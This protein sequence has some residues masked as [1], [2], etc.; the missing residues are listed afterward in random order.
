MTTSPT[1]TSAHTLRHGRRAVTVSIGVDGPTLSL[2]LDGRQLIPVKLGITVDGQPFGLGS[3]ITAVSQRTVTERVEMRTGKAAR[4]RDVVHEELD[5]E[6]TNELGRTWGV[7]LRVAPDGF[8][9]RYR[10]PG[11]TESVQLGAELTSFPTAPDQRAWVL[12]Y[13][14]WYETPRF[15]SDLAELSSGDY[16]FP[17]LLRVAA[18]DFLLFSESDIDGRFSGTHP[19]YTGSAFALATADPIVTLAGGTLTPW[20]VV[21]AGTLADVVE[22]SLVDELAP[23]AAQELQAASWIR[24]GRAAWSWWSS[25]YSG[26]YLNHQKRFADYAAARGWEHVLVD[27]GWDETWM[28][29]LVA[30]ASLRGVQV[31]VWSSWSDLDGPDALAKLALWRS[32]GVAGI[33]VDFMESEAL[34]RY[35]WYDAIIAESARVGL[36]VNF[37]GSVIPRGWARTHP[38]VMSYEGIRGAEYYVFYGDPLTA[39]HNV[40]QPFTRNVVGSMD[41]T[42]VTFSAPKRE[43]SDAHELALAVA[44]ES[45]IVHFADD[46]TE[47]AARPLAEA[48]L[49]EIPTTW[50]ETRLL[51]GTPDTEAI[52]ARR[53]G[54]RWFVGC[55]AAGEPRTVTLDLTSL[56]LVDA[57]AWFITDGPD[58]LVAVEL[59][60]FGPVE[61]D[62]ARNGGFA[63][64]IAPTPV[65]LRTAVP[66]PELVAPDASP[67]VQGLDSRGQALIQTSPDAVLRL[68]P[69]WY[70]TG[71]DGVWT[72]EPAAVAPGSVGVITVEAPAAG[73]FPPAVRHVRVFTRLA[74]GEH[75]AS[76]LPFL[77]CSNTVG[78]VERDLANGGGD[79]RDGA[80]MSVG[81]VSHADGIG[82]SDR[83]S[84]TFWLGGYAQRFTV[85]VGVDDETP[86]ATATARVVIDDVVVA[87]LALVGGEPAELVDL[88]LA[89]ATLL[90]LETIP[91]PSEAHIDWAEARIHVTE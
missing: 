1:L 46:V 57:V 39:A 30:H 37:H 50:E 2:E 5:V 44:F 90:R 15:G 25:Q 53:H 7:L 64:V 79:P 18:N 63:A 22:S 8:A 69:G 43:T 14:T 21:I 51:G 27:C 56:G 34:E 54:D 12:E 26:A 36:M 52:V 6:L 10:M 17:L 55:I 47:Y 59:P 40:I 29:E 48:F 24:P 20:R 72:V 74:A 65:G 76:A 42:P 87:E 84:V 61:L 82:V 91:G 77:S 70:A 86:T 45:G 49:A 66:S 9:F 33:K 80:P 75:R 16:G 73:D 13:Q 31:H 62:L 68:P 78:P 71:G 85:L 67:A 60:V 4:R 81:G 58:G 28:P 35:R 11:D 32:W 38:H 41:Y 88:Q 23:A 19:V 83:S 89:N 3:T